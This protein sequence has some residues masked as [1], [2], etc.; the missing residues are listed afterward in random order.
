[1]KTFACDL[2]VL[3]VCEM[4]DVCTKPSDESRCP[5]RYRP[6]QL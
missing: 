2:E 3:F 6:G 5:V 4:C 1:M